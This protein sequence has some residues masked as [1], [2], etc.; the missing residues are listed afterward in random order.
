MFNSIASF[1]FRRLGGVP[2]FRIYGKACRETEWRQIDVFATYRRNS[3]S[4]WPAP[5][6]RGTCIT[7]TA[8][9]ISVGWDFAE[10]VLREQVDEP[11]SR[12]RPVEVA[13]GRLHDLDRRQAAGAGPFAISSEVLAHECGH[14]R[15]ALRLG[16]A[17]LPTGALFTLFREGPHWYNRFENQA[18]EEGQFGGIINGTVHPELMRRVRQ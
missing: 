16:M 18:S 6:F 17:Y 2:C 11:A 4:R 5:L 3:D 13:G 12:G 9:V 10:E 7:W 8:S 15:Q 14:T 1:L